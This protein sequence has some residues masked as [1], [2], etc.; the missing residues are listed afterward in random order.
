MFTGIV[1]EVGTVRARIL[2]G[3]AMRFVIEAPRIAA[4]LATGDSVACE[5]V[6]LTVESLEPSGFSARAVPETLAKTTLGGWKTGDPVNLE[7]SLTPST[8]MGGH[9]V[10][11]HTDGVCEV[12]EVRVLAEGGGRELTV[13]LPAEF[14]RYCVYKGSIALGGVSLTVASVDR[15]SVRIAVIPHPLASTT[16][17]R[18]RAGDRLNFEADILAKYLEKQLALQASG[19]T[20][21]PAPAQAWGASSPR[22]D[23]MQVP[24]AQS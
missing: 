20:T 16:L 13:R 19:G 3:D 10:L 4:G 8:P 1:Q 23:R 12:T 18:L 21:Q 17:G 14:A 2:A 7:P 15:D 5:G 6:C 22:G 9:F 24:E 11:G